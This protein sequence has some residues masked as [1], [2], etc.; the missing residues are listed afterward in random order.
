[1]STHRPYHISTNSIWYWL[2]PL[3]LTVALLTFAPLSLVSDGEIRAGARP[4]LL[5]KWLASVNDD[6]RDRDPR[7]LRWMAFLCCVCCRTSRSHSYC[8]CTCVSTTTSNGRQTRTFYLLTT[9]AWIDPFYWI[10]LHPQLDKAKNL[11]MI[12]EHCWLENVRNSKKNARTSQ[13][14]FWYL[15][16]FLSWPQVKN[17]L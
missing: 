10:E 7:R 16:V 1:M 14:Y 13:T 4:H 11:T 17:F 12:T 6:G 15:W 9:S 8:Q 2:L 3:S 5:Y